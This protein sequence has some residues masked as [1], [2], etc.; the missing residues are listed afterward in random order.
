MDTK[1]WKKQFKNLRLSK[2]WTQAQMAQKL[3]VSQSLINLLESG[4]RNFTQSLLDTIIEKL[5]ITLYEFMFENSSDAES[6]YQPGGELH[7]AVTSTVGQTVP[8]I[9]WDQ[10]PSFLNNDLKPGLTH[11]SVYTPK[12]AGKMSFALSIED[13]TMQ[14]RFMQDD[15]IIVDPSRKPQNNDTCVVRINDKYEFKVFAQT[16]EGIKLDVYNKKYPYTSIPKDS[17][18]DYEIIGKVIGLIAKF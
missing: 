1:F 16:L 5:D 18:I 11:K 10:I 12:I 13:D 6:L 3:G 7:D 8:L 15:K 4:K 14:P 17:N 9:E 2:G